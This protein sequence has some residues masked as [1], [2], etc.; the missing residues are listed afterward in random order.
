MNF[1]CK[2]KDGKVVIEL[3]VDKILT[4]VMTEKQL[5]DLIQ[6]LSCQDYIIKCVADQIIEGFTDNI[7]C[8]S[9][10]IDG[11]G[12]LQVARKRIIDNISSIKDISFIDMERKVEYLEDV[13]AR[14]KDE[15]ISNDTYY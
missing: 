10:C 9:W 11:S 12:A 1:E 15:L 14:L 6:S 4:E 5:D 8:G 2:E 7:S 3:D 13:I